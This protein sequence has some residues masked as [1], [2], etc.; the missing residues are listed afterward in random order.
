MRMISLMVLSIGLLFLVVGPLQAEGYLSKDGKLTHTL[1]VSQLSGR[2]SADSGWKWTIA[3]DGTW[4][5]SK[6]FKNEAT[7][8]VKR[9]LSAEGLA[10]LV[11]L[12]AKYELAKLPSKSGVSPRVSPGV[13]PHL[14]TLQ[15][16]KQQAQ[17][18]GAAPPKLDTK[19]PA[20]SVESRFAGIWLGVKELLS[21]KRP[22]G[23]TN[24]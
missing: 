4:T 10:K 8:A 6:I 9:K 20:G 13:K 24:R 23:G 21:R 14:T 5:L 2:S 1:E 18:A 12:L 11:A 3:P 7:L 16:G 22:R 15:F 19:N 17:L